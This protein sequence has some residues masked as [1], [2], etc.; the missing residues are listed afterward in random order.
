M[1]HFSDA[2]GT[3]SMVTPINAEKNMTPVPE[4]A[5][6]RERTASAQTTGQSK[7][8]ANLATS[9]TE[10]EPD[11]AS[12]R[13]LYQLES[14]RLETPGSAIETPEQARGL[15]AKVLQQFS[16]TPENALKAQGSGP[17]HLFDKLLST[18]PS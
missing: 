17:S 12:A 13:Q 15:L 4:R 8:T 14:E 11:M 10:S 5:Q 18:A 2:R 16:T 6:A 3:Q 1:S 9:G 7:E